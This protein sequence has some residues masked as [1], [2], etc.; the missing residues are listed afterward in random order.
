MISVRQIDLRHEEIMLPLFSAI[1]V[2]NENIM[3]EMTKVNYSYAQGPF[4]GLPWFFAAKILS[5]S[6]NYFLQN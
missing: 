1:L 4:E 3:K 6:L 5:F 2:V